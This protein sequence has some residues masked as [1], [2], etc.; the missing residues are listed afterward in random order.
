MK[1]KRRKSPSE[2]ARS[3]VL[4]SWFWYPLGGI[5]FSVI[6]AR[7]LN[8]L[9]PAPTTPLYWGFFLWT[10]AAGI[11]IYRLFCPPVPKTK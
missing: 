10:L 6:L 5:L 2:L 11:A 9:H 8:F 1:R 3:L 7:V 4:W